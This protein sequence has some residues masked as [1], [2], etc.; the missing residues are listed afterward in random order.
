MYWDA[1]HH[2]QV[3]ESPLGGPA[4]EWLHAG[5]ADARAA[6][7]QRLGVTS[8]RLRA[9]GLRLRLTADFDERPTAPVSA[10]LIGVAVQLIAVDTA[11]HFMETLYQVDDV[12]RPLWRGRT[13]VHAEAADG[14]APLP[15]AIRCEAEGW[16][17]LVRGS[18]PVAP[19][20]LHG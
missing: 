20:S 4:P 12:W 9:E 17:R 11:L 8:S 18:I 14:P 2:L 5:L 15:A 16:L 13:R 1:Y 7:L 19:A 10:E 6:F 3:R